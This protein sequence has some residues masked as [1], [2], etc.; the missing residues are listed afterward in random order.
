[1][2]VDHLFST[3]S[4]KIIG[5]WQSTV[6]SP[7]VGSPNVGKEPTIGGTTFGKTPWNQRWHP[8]I[9]A[10]Q[11]NFEPHTTYGTSLAMI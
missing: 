8:Q 4:S 6:V 5:R 10:A 9:P 2:N 11:F 7:N 3:A 1:M